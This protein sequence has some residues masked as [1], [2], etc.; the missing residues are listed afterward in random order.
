MSHP[1]DSRHAGPPA[2]TFHLDK[3]R[4]ALAGVCSGI[5]NYA[6]W[7]VTMVRLAFVLTTIFLTGTPILLY[8][9]MWAI[10][11]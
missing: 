9:I 4:A 8:L 11:D 7:D 3:N 1:D 2:R 5:A 6:G 10:A